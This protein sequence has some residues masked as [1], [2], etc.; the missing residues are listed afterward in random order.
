[1]PTVSAWTEPLLHS[2][3]N[4]CW[5]L[6]WTDTHLYWVAK[7]VVHV[8]KVEGQRRLHCDT[9]PAVE[10]DIENL[11]FWHGTLVPAYA[12]VSPETITAQ[13]I[14]AEQDETVRDALL[15][16]WKWNW[17][18]KEQDRLTKKKDN[19]FANH[20]QKAMGLTR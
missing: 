12:I 14:D 17:P 4:G 16:L 3:L 7:P 8:E 10:N 13:E 11:Y 9:G 6:F 20:L 18:K 2:F 5:Y 1:M 19:P 15:Q